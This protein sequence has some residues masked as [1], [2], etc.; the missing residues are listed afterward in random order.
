MAARRF[1][2]LNAFGEAVFQNILPTDTEA[3]LLA[4]EAGLPALDS[5]YPIANG[6][7]ISRALR[8]I[9]YNTT[10]FDR[11][12]VV[13]QILAISAE[14]SISKEA[15]EI[16][17]RLFYLYLSG[18]HASVDQ[19]AASAKRLLISTNPTARALGLEALDA[20]LEAMHFTADHDFQFGAHSRDYGYQP[21]NYVDIVHWYRTALALASEIAFSHSPAAEAAKAKIA[22][23]LRDLWAIEGLR[24]EL[25]KLFAKCAAQGF[26]REGW[27]AV[28]HTRHYDENDK[29]SENYARLSKLEETLRPVDLV[30]RVRGRVLSTVGADYDIDDLQ[31]DSTDSHTVAMEKK[32][33]ET[34]A[35][36]KEVATNPAAFG[37]LLPEI[38]TAAGNLWHFGMGLARGAEH[39][40]IIWQELSQQLAVSAAHDHNVRVFCGML[41]FLNVSKPELANELLDEALENGPLA[42]H[43]PSLQTAVTLDQPAMDRLTR[44]LALGKAATPSYENLA[45]G[46]ATNKVPAADLAKFLLVLAKAPDGVSVAG[47]VL[48][49]QFFADK[50][51]KCNH[52]PELIAVGRELLAQVKFSR[53]D[54]RNHFNPDGLIEACLLGNEGSAVAKMICEKLKQ[55]IAAHETSGYDH[56]Q[57]LRCLFRAQPTVA[58]DAFFT[59]DEDSNRFGLRFMREASYRQPTFLD[60]V[61]DAA[62]VEWCL[63]SP[64]ARFP[65]IASA[66]SAFGIS[67]EHQPS[68]WAPIASLLVHSAPN[69]V[70]A[71][72]ALA[73]RLRPRSWSGSRCNNPETNAK[74]LDEFDTRGNSKLDEFLEAEK[75]S[76]LREA[77]VVREWESRRDKGR[78]ER[79]E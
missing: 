6:R 47:R 17:A 2:N 15:A 1:G 25:E 42:A 76:L 11:C 23:N 69:P 31:D 41:W 16:H 36:G 10:L 14:A 78:D 74:L 48:A 34:E 46:R 24:D 3:G 79:F 72:Q 62:L 13:L 26:W 52:A 12:L 70:G 38:V 43:F 53:T 49:M 66:A 61:S 60:E 75:A 56:N 77:G 51:D 35:L 37:E 50:Q 40:K 27:L 9:A 32:A 22:T 59:G 55:A 44:S 65:V 68:R 5:S 54:Q 63:Q 21:N 57:L 18:T 28:K 8:S 39:P 58:L 45:F 33:T 20:M 30:Q 7:Y 67:A 4:I 73:A 19:R 29:A 71:M 64:V